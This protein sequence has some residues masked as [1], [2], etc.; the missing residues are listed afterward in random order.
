[1]VSVTPEVIYRE[2]DREMVE[3]VPLTSL[4]VESDGPWPYKG[5]LE[6]MPSGPWVVTRVAEEIAKIKQTPV[7]EVI[8]QIGANT[9]ALF[10]LPWS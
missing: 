7:D 5:E 6:G 10:D 8:D 2:R 4:L 1:V 3:A 9:C